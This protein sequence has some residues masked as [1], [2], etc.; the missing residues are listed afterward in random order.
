MLELGS[1]WIAA[2][3]HQT[4]SKAIDFLQNVAIRR[5]HSHGKMLIPI[6]MFLFLSMLSHRKLSVCRFVHQSNV[7]IIKI[8]WIWL[9]FYVCFLVEDM[10]LKT[11]RIMDDRVVRELSDFLLFSNYPLCQI[12][13]KKYPIIEVFSM[14]FIAVGF[15]SQSTYSKSFIHCIY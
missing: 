8:F 10:F 12:V 15:M 7:H 5:E 14:D 4:K 1:V 6:S 2:S 13:Y 11:L 3:L 9:D